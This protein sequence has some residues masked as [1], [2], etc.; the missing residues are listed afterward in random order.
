MNLDT[1]LLDDVSNGDISFKRQ[2]IEMIHAEMAEAIPL[3][4]LLFETNDLVAIHD[5]SH[6]LKTS[7][8]YIRWAKIEEQNTYIEASSKSKKHDPDLLNYIKRLNKLLP[9][10]TQ[11]IESLATSL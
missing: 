9:D 2:L 6:K 10:Y 4:L 11:A 8:G 3:M 1:T 7:L 5:L